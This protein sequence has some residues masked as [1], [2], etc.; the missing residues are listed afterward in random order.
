[1]GN[2]DG[3]ERCTSRIGVASQ[4]MGHG[5]DWVAVVLDGRLI[6]DGLG[7]RHGLGT[8][9]VAG[10]DGGGRRTELGLVCELGSV[11]VDGQ[12]GM[13]LGAATAREARP[14]HVWMHRQ[15][16][17]RAKKSDAGRIELWAQ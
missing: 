5:T 1:M 3:V 4:S 14:G 9:W 13:A 2:G 11:W 10:L 8:D 16:R 6:E 15:R 17:Q 12:R 7:R